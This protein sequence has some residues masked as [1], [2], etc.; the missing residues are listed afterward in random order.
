MKLFFS[1]LYYPISVIILISSF[2]LF[3]VPI[4]LIVFPFNWGTR[5]RLTSPMWKLFGKT[6]IYIVCLCK[7]YFE[8]HRPE[9]ERNLNNPP[10][11]YVAN[12]QSF[13]DIPLML[14]TAQIPPIMK[15]EIL[16]IPI[17]GV[18]GYSSGA[19]IVN[20]KKGESRKKVFAQ[21]KYR[22]SSF[23]KNLQYYPEGT[24]TK[25]G[26]PPKTIEKIKKP[27][28]LFAYENNT[29]VYPVSMYGTPKVLNKY[30]W[31]FYGKKLGKIMH[32]PVYPADYQDGESFCIAVWDK[33]RNGY[34]DLE[35]K[36]S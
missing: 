14:C 10:G 19:M 11:L 20:R 4:S 35:K 36:L 34:F 30:G 18:C 17:F 26:L 15:K 13:M 7:T 2:I 9:E 6:S 28:M 23:H 32:E 33:V 27:L 29:P 24:R 12:H 3:V 21:A 22:L 5:L 1:I 8:D 16:Y 25:G 31:I